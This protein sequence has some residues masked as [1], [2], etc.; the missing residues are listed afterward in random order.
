MSK[1]IL[2][3]HQKDLKWLNN[4]LNQAKMEKFNPITN[5]DIKAD[6]FVNQVKSFVEPMKSFIQ[7]KEYRVEDDKVIYTNFEGNRIYPDA[8]GNLLVGQGGNVKIK[9][10][11]DLPEYNEIGD[12]T[13]FV[14]GC[15]PQ[16][17][18][19]KI[20][21][22]QLDKSILNDLGNPELQYLDL[23]QI[24]T[25]KSQEAI[26]Y[27]S[28]IHKQQNKDLYDIPNRGTF[29]DGLKL[30]SLQPEIDELNS[31]AN[32]VILT[33]GKDFFLGSKDTNLDDAGKKRKKHYKI[34]RTYHPDEM[35]N[36]YTFE[37]FERILWYFWV[38]ILVVTQDKNS[39]FDSTTNRKKFE[40]LTDAYNHLA[41]LRR[42]EDL[43]RKQ[44]K[45]KTVIFQDKD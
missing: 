45:I 4:Y 40:S 39:W 9:T 29:D 24:G 21:L 15:Y 3:K 30:H 18:I 5:D 42:L 8:N 32:D 19:K 27:C 7:E 33:N 43:P 11:F 25:K 1:E 41:Y 17:E 31:L 38:P 6:A 14:G 44:N 35:I 36:P 34:V 20:D 23:S 2:A 28:L 26:D 16:E 22:S 12:G 37:I 10:C 13:V